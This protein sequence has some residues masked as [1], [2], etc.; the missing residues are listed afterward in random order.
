[1][2]KILILCAM[3]LACGC[4]PE[5]MVACPTFATSG[6]SVGVTNQATGQPLCDATVTAAEGSYSETLL[7]NGCR[8]IGAWERPGSYEVRAAASGFAARTIGDVRV[9]MGTGQCPHVQESRL[10]IALVP[11]R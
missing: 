6:L 3:A 9:A 7:A 4:P 8:Y 10:D 5:D 2:K 11:N 1:M